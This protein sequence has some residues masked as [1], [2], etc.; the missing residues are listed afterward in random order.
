MAVIWLR[1]PAQ[2]SRT[3]FLVNLVEYSRASDRY[4]FNMALMAVRC[5]PSYMYD[6]VGHRYWRWLHWEFSHG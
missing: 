1:S 2:V 4:G 6:T 5:R 3:A